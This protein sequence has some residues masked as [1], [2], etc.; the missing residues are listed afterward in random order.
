MLLVREE[1]VLEVKE[2]NTLQIKEADLPVQEHKY[3]E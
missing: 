2:L 1:S 3:L